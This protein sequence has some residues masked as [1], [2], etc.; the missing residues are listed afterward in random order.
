MKEN[1]KKEIYDKEAYFIIEVDRNIF[2]EQNRMLNIK[3]IE[4]ALRSSLR[5][6]PFYGGGLNRD[7]N[8][9]F[10]IFFDKDE[11]EFENSDGFYGKKSLI[12]KRRIE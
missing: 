8:Y 4:D 2:N 7:A 11:W 6:F 5:I 9:Q 3:K 10:G 12:I 1:L